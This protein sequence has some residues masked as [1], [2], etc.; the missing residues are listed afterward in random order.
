MKT[1]NERISRV[2]FHRSKKQKQE[3]EEEEEEIG[4]SY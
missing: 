1:K 4:T 3:E 2:K